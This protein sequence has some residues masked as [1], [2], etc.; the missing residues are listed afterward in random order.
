MLS[1]KSRRTIIHNI[2]TFQ[3]EE[4]AK[5]ESASVRYRAVILRPLIKAFQIV[6]N[7]VDLA[8]RRR[9]IELWIAMEMEILCQDDSETEIFELS[10]G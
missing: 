10:H 3:Q 8:C 1:M 5:R 2:I 7:L 6:G 9:G 4:E